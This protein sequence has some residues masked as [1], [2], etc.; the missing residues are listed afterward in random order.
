MNTVSGAAL[1][2]VRLRLQKASFQDRMISSRPWRPA[3]HG[4]RQQQVDH[5][6][7]GVGAVDAGRFQDF[8]GHVIEVGEGHPHRDGQVDQ[9]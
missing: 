6:L 9:V 4:G 8:L 1:T 3:R 7:P 5:F 2:L